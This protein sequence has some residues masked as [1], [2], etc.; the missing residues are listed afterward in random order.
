M[1]PPPSFVP[2]VIDSLLSSECA[3]AARRSRKCRR[4][5]TSA[6]ELEIDGVAVK[7]GCDTDVQ[8]SE[9][10]DINFIALARAKY[11]LVHRLLEPDPKL[12]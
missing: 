8:A 7:V 5:Q 2:A 9:E 3:P 12:S 4:S 10:V 1:P 6:V 11:F